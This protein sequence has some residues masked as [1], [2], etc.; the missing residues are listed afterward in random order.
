MQ[1]VSCMGDGSTTEFYF[2]FPFYTNTD[3]I[4][5][6]N[7]QITTDYTVIGT[8]IGS[9]ADMPYIGGKIVFNVAPAAT[10]SI[11]IYR[12]LP[13]TRIVDYQPTEKINPTNLNQDMNYM[14][15]VLKD[16]QDKF[17]TFTEQYND[18]VNKE[19]TENLLSK[20]HYINELID[21]DEIINKHLSNCITTI[22]QDIKL[23]L[24]DG[25]L[26]I[27][28]GSKFYKPN[29]SGI[30]D[31]Y[32]VS[33]DIRWTGSSTGTFFV[34]WTGSA[35]DIVSG[36]NCY[37]GSTAPTGIS[38]YSAWYDTTNNVIKKTNDSGSTWQGA[39]TLPICI[40]NSVSGSGVVSIKQTFNGFGFIGSTVFVLPGVKGLIPNGR[41]GDGTL[42]STSLN[43]SSVITQTFTGTANTVLAITSNQ[44]ITEGSGIWYNIENNYNYY[45][46]G[47]VTPYNAVII[48]TTT[49]TS[50][51]VS[52]FYTKKTITIVN[53]ED[54]ANLTMPSKKYIDL[55]LGTSGTSYIAPADG[56]FTI[57]K[58]GSDGEWIYMLD[59][60]TGANVSL[61]Y[62][63]SVNAR[64]LIPVARGKS[65]Q[66][67]YTASGT[68]NYFRF[69][70]ANG[71]Q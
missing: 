45:S 5:L 71:A 66:I 21:N 40:I 46:S 32:I 50:G 55:T 17:D 37:S 28:S 1:K 70:Y 3:I 61:S 51:K 39:Y 62:A 14:M 67:Q 13:L 65:I 15:E 20:I 27:K 10:D 49:L 7:T 44:I 11:T 34:F 18:I 59:N 23:E 52:N 47:S 42:K 8:Q 16:M 25:Y 57:N 69:I 63:A 6:K 35:I 54:V 68:T 36:N 56:Y 43:I 30:F 29:G 53:E 41:N 64:L 48:G 22:P 2:D 24:D 12:H 38:Q 4:V 19:S 60:S 9:N 31:T 33:N 26:V 58:G